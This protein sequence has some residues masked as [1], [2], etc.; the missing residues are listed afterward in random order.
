VVDGE[1]IVLDV[2]C[3]EVHNRRRYYDTMYVDTPS[4]RQVLRFEVED[5]A[6]GITKEKREKLFRPF[7]QV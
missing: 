2:K 1:L 6:I 5:T 4:G 7:Q 3:A